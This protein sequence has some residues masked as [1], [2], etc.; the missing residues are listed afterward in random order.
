MVTIGSQNIT[1][2]GPGGTPLGILRVNSI[3][4][5]A[6]PSTEE[7]VFLDYIFLEGN[8]YSDL[9]QERF[10][11]KFPATAVT[12]RNA[13]RREIEKFSETGCVGRSHTD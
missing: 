13:V 5:T 2:R 7:R 8:R 9:L 3:L 6:V 10:A 4:L 12:D 11:E 1:V